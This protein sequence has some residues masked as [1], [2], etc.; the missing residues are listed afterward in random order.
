MNG[1]RVWTYDAKTKSIIEITSRVQDMT[2]R[3]CGSI[4]NDVPLSVRFHFVEPAFFWDLGPYE[5]GKYTALLA[6]GFQAFEVPSKEALNLRGISSLPIRIR[7][8]SPDGWTTYSPRFDLD[9]KRQPNFEWH[10]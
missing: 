9:L 2:K 10:R 4:R 6:D 8:D 5:K 7:Y 1:K 3:Y